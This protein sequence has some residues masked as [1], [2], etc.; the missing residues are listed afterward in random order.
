MTRFVQRISLTPGC[1]YP[2]WPPTAPRVGGG[3]GGLHSTTEK[4]GTRAP[5]VGAFVR[6]HRDPSGGVYD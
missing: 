2:L 3:S 6:G 1:A 5:R 4:I